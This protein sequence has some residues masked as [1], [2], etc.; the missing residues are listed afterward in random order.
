MPPPLKFAVVREDPALE[1]ELVRRFG[2]R[3]PLVVASGG[4]T[5]LTLTGAEVDEVTAFDLNPTQL[6][7]VEAKRAA[8]ARGDLAALG[9]ESADGLHELGAFEGLFRVLR[10]FIDEFVT[11]LDFAN[12][13]WSAAFHTTFNDA[14][15]HAMFGPAATQHAAPGSYPGYFQRAFERGLR[16][17]G[18]NP[19]LDHV[20]RGMYRRDAMPPYITAAERAPLS[21]VEGSLL[22][23]PHLEGF[24]LF[25][26]SNVFDWSDDALVRDWAGALAAAAPG[27]VVLLRQLNNQRDL[28]AFFAPHYRFD[29]ALGRALFERDQS[30]FYERI[31]VGVRR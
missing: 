24:D 1:L 22:D 26:L 29:D 14:F 20:F 3:R 4:C 12:P 8:R 23:V 13:Y 15:L 16:R 10:R 28:R 7:H 19:F 2:C 21:L 30:L 6:A 17:E 11:P 5:A 25:S 31:E 18:S 27:S 9:V